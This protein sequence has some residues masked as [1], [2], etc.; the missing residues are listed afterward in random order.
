MQTIQPHNWCGLLNN[1]RIITYS[2]VIV[3]V[4]LTVAVR[5]LMACSLENP[6]LITIAIL[7]SEGAGP[8]PPPPDPAAGLGG[9]K[10]EEKSVQKSH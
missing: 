3:R 7:S 6:R 9:S 5:A 4:F 10:G 1:Y 8:A 2:H